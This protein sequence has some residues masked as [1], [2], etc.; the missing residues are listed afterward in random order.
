MTATI[1]PFRPRA[2]RVPIARPRL[3]DRD[4]LLVDLL[5]QPSVPA[6]PELRE[7][8][9]RLMDETIRAW[10]AEADGDGTRR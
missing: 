4:P 8:S 5:D 7:E 1:L 6:T 3:I 2:P 10:R 9:R